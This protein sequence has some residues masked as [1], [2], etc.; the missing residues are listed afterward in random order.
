MAER[1]YFGILKVVTED[2]EIRGER[3]N[4]SEFIEDQAFEQARKIAK[5]SGIGSPEFKDLIKESAEAAFGRAH[6]MSTSLRRGVF[7]FGKRLSI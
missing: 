7:L 1:V 3:I 4:T 2:P 6:L 5:L